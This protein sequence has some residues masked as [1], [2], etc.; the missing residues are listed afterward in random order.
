MDVPL[1]VWI[2]SFHERDPVQQQSQQP[3]RAGR[4]DSTLTSADDG[5]QR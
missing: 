5:S 4:L 1:A 2:K 3:D